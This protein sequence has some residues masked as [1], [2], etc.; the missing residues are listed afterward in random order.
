MIDDRRARRL[1]GESIRE[2]GILVT[3]FAPLD[4]FFQAEPPPAR[5]VGAMALLGLPCL[6]FGIMIETKVE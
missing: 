1:L 2:I 3:V 6:G 5:I 4:A